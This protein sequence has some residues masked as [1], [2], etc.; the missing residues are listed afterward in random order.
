MRFLSADPAIEISNSSGVLRVT[1]YPARSWPIA[2]L[3]FVV[4]AAA[5]AVIFGKWAS[6]PFEFR[7]VFV[8]GL[9]SGAAGLI[10]QISGTEVIEI[11]SNKMT[12]RKEVHG[13]ERKR[14]Y[15]VRLCR[16][17]Q[18]MERSEHSP[19]R[20]QFKIGWRTITVGRGL[21]ENQAIQILTALQQALPKLAEQLCSYPEGKKHFSTLGLS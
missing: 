17:L 3:E 2:L 5:A 4:L 1:I 19:Q 18:W 20:L 7:A 9:L 15:E 11:D 8:I 10:F 12:L 6:M 14:E 13:W 21:T 16:E